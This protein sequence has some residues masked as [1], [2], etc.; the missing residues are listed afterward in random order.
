MKTAKTLFLAILAAAA[1]GLAGCGGGTGD[2][3]FDAEW[4]AAGD[5]SD[6][7]PPEQLKNPGEIPGSCK[8]D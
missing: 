7:I 8:G 2:E 6:C 3:E 1:L 5:G 4:E